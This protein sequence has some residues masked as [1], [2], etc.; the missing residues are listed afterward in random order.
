[1]RT[2]PMRSK[3]IWYDTLRYKIHPLRPQ[4]K[5]HYKLERTRCTLACGIWFEIWTPVSVGSV[6]DSQMKSQGNTKGILSWFFGSVLRLRL[7]TQL[8]ALNQIP[9]LKECLIIIR[10]CWNIFLKAPSQWL[11]L[12]KSSIEIEL[13]TELIAKSSLLTNYS[14]GNQNFFN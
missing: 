6:L 9:N 14:L 12:L 5:S 2:K 13:R 11:N 1:M 4:D 3:W 8:E 7:I 10:Q